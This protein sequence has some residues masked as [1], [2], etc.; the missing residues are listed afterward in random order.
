MEHPLETQPNSTPNL[1]QWQAYLDYWRNNHLQNIKPS[2]LR[3]G[4]FPEG[5]DARA[6]LNRLISPFVKNSIV[7]IGCGYGRLCEAFS[8][9]F[10]LGLDINPEAIEQA[11]LLHPNY[12]FEPIHYIDNYPPA[13][14]YLAYT[15]LL[16]VDDRAIQDCIA[17]LCAAAPIVIIAENLFENSRRNWLGLPK[18]S[19]QPKGEQGPEF[20]RTRKDY[21]ALMQQNGFVLE[22]EIRK[23]YHYY[24]NT[25][26]SFL[27]FR[28]RSPAPTQFSAFPQDL[29]NP[30]LKFVGVYEDGWLAQAASLPLRLPDSA[31]QLCIQGLLPQISLP[32]P[33][34]I[35][36]GAQ[37]EPRLTE[38]R[39]SIGDR[40]FFKQRLTPGDFEIKCQIPE[41]AASEIE[42]KL[43]FSNCQKLPSPDD[44]QVSILLK[45][46]GFE[47]DA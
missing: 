2:S 40:S 19:G 38:L 8:S 3:Y 43:N 5:W 20:R 17:K 36:N 44:R 42:L 39:L 27:V 41:S 21:Q 15:V 1:N 30:D 6:V 28:K 18:Y 7:E 33:S 47:E 26:I 13:D 23:P 25:E 34:Q 35:R 32:Q 37:S 12:R 31:S 45:F 16:H 46:I 14:V 24:A 10:Y 11:R 29:S 9:Q 22:E 4:E